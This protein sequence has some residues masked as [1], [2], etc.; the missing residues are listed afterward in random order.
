MPP[1]VVCEHVWAT[2]DV[3]RQRLIFFLDDDLFDE[4][5]YLLR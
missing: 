2:V 5:E 3:A 1:G 4:R